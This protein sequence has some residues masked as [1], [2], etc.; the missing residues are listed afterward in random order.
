MNYQAG[1]LYRFKSDGSLDWLISW[2][3]HTAT[4]CAVTKGEDYPPGWRPGESFTWPRSTFERWYE[5]PI[6]EPAPEPAPDP[7]RPIAVGDRVE[8]LDCIRTENGVSSPP[9]FQ[10]TIDRI[11]AQARFGLPYRVRLDH[12]VFGIDG[13]PMQHVWAARVERVS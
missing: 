8:I 3:D 12:V 2:D 9:G 4:V 13:V 1:K 5:G 6:A 7:M 10:G 11:D